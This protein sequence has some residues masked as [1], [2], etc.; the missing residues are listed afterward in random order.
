MIKQLK[1][2]SN[3]PLEQLE[4][5]GTPKTIGEVIPHLNGIQ[6]IENNDGSEGGIWECSPGKFEREINAGHR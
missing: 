4:D 5:W 6:I 1:N 2:A 3:I